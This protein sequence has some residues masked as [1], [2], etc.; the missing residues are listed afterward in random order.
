MTERGKTT[1]RVSL[2]SKSARHVTHLSRCLNFFIKRDQRNDDA[3]SYL[4]DF[5]SAPTKCLHDWLTTTK[6][7]WSCMNGNTG[8]N[9]RRKLD[10]SRH[11]RRLL[12]DGLTLLAKIVQR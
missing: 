6:C 9:C 10:G 7:R 8:C 1:V 11:D 12:Q 4:K 3:L 5:A 2:L